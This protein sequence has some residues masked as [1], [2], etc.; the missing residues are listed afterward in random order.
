MLALSRL[1]E[2]A[3]ACPQRVVFE[4]GTGKVLMNVLM[5]DAVDFEDWGVLRMIER[6]FERIKEANAPKYSANG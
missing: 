2:A 3:R 4:I 5:L 6:H 1:I